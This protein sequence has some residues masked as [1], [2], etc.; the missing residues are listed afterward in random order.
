MNRR[1]ILQQAFAL[2]LISLCGKLAAAAST[3]GNAG[4]TPLTRCR[5]GD[6]AWP[7]AGR[8]ARL[9]KKVGG[10]LSAVKS[11][12]DACRTGTASS[13]CSTL[14]KAL[15]NPY[16]VGDH[17]GLTQTSGWVDA[18]KS[19]PSAYA[20]AAQHTADVVAAVK[21]A[22]DHN[23]RLVVK[24]GGHSYQ[25]TSNAADAL[26]VWTRKM[27]RITMHDAFVGHGCTGRQAAQPAVTI[28]SGATW[29]RV[30]HTVTRAGRYVQGGGCGTVGVAGLIQSGGFGSFSKR[31]G[32]AAAGLIEAEIVTADGSVRIANACTNPDL[33][34]ALKGGGG[35][36]Y[37]VVT[38]LTLRTRGLPQY[39]G[40]V[41]GA[42]KARSDDAFR[43]LIAR[44]MAFYNDSLFNPHWGESV[45]FGRDNTLNV[46][47]VFQGVDQQQ[48]ERTWKPFLDWVK[49]APQD[50]TIDAPVTLTAIPARHFF[51]P[52][53]LRRHHP[54]FVI[55]D[56][57][58]GA[59]VN[60]V[61][62]A[63]DHG[64]VGFFLHGYDSLWM[65]AELLAS[66]QQARLVDAL[67]ASSRHWRASLHF[68][69]GLAGAPA[70]A[71]AEAKDMPTNPAVQNAFA[72]AIIASA[73]PPAFAGMPGNAPDMAVARQNGASVMAAIGELRKVAPDGGAY[74]SEANFFDKSWQSA[75]WGPN[76][77]RLSAVK[78]KYDPAGLFFVHNGVGSEEWSADG[79]TRLAAQP[80]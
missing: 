5:P 65:P 4:K 70:Q 42:V 21:F 20:V 48:A 30:Y 68:N 19:A 72:L 24:G 40:T 37:G 66:Q 75:Y 7:P 3:P 62:W 43:R 52:A 50:Y 64:Q 25:G 44:F 46:S 73:G 34:W 45:A 38:R 69:K 18:W 63:G 53:Y 26:L 22:R 51:D 15:K 11:P 60:N 47:M 57:R 35:G 67:F 56:D 29:M 80:T 33:W 71:I 77:P 49:A 10:Q 1:K 58:P 9:N 13:A 36:S 28:E 78:K 16:Y 76:Y 79:F 31:Y 2:P 54:D 12:L 61:Y 6:A 59:P 32:M 41:F 74:V 55:A 23:L 27:D 17:P 8:W 39:F 14:V